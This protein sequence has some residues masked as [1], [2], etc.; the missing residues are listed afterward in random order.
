[1]LRLQ[2][3]TTVEED[4]L[5]AQEYVKM[6]EDYRKVFDFGRTWSYED[7]VSK[8]KTLREIRRDMHK[9]REWRNE[10]DR[11]KISN[12]VGCLYIDS[13]SLRND[14][15]PI[16][17][18]TLDRIKLLLLN[19]SRDTCLQ[20]LEDTHSRIA[21]LQARPVMLDEFMTYQVMH[22][23]QVEAKKAVL[24]AASQVDDMY[25]MLSAYEQKVPTGDQVKH[26]DLREAANQFVQELSAGKEFIADNKHAQQDTLA[27]NIKALNEELV[28]L[29]FSLTQG[30]YIN[31]DADP[32]QVVADLDGVM[33]HIEELKAASETYKEYEALFERDASDFSLVA[34]TEKEAAAKHHLWKSLY[35][36]MEKSHN[37][38]EDAILDEDG[39]VALSIEQ[40]RAE[41]EEYSSR[42]YKLGKAAREDPV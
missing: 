30:D 37:W 22:A 17:S 32:E 27:E 34:Q 4:Y 1:S 36:F 21:L 42:A 24:A 31:A 33:T 5:A 25:D 13:K 7:Y 41:V 39:K 18:S 38:T 40:I 16:T 12:V 26:D 35:D 2:L 20:V 10:L 19:M 14:L 6:F 28:T 8:A 29:S 23:Q 3:N 15:L 11:M 9:Q